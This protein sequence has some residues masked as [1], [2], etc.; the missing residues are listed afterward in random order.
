[1][2]RPAKLGKDGLQS[3]RV[4]SIRNLHKRFDWRIKMA[5]PKRYSGEEL[6]ARLIFSVGII[7][8]VVFAVSV[9]GFVYALMFVT[10]PVNQQSPNDAAFIDLLKTLTVFLTGSLG[11]LVMSNGMKSKKKEESGTNPEE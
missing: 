4:R 10:Q 1:M 7:L 9:F 11:G 2:S 5:K 6:H 8:A 3:T